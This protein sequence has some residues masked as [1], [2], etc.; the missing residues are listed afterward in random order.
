MTSCEIVCMGAAQNESPVCTPIGSMFSMVQTV[1]S[2]P[3]A[4]RTTS[5]SSS[6]QPRTLSSTSTSV[7]GDAVRP[8]AT[9]V[10]SSSML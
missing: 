6:S 4:S 5:N 2:C 7:T 9:V 1:M 10:L 8:R 3:L